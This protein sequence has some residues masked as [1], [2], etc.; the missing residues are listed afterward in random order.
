MLSRHV[1][2]ELILILLGIVD[3]EHVNI[4]DRS[5]AHIVECGAGSSDVG[6]GPVR[7]VMEDIDRHLTCQSV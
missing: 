1:G 4:Y 2:Q 5:G 6:S 3:A 7:V